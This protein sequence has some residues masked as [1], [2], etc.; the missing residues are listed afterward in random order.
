ML[1]TAVLVML[2][3]CILKE[4]LDWIGEEFGREW[5]YVYV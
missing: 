3:N 5:I 4:R 2:I 1:Y